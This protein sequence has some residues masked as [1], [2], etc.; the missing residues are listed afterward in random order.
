MVEQLWQMFHFKIQDGRRIGIPAP[1]MKLECKL[2]TT[3][4]VLANAGNSILGGSLISQVY[5]LYHL[6]II[7]SSSGITDFSHDTTSLVRV[8]ETAA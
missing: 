8:C 1:R 5:C 4:L 7:K 3:A 2:S 6:L